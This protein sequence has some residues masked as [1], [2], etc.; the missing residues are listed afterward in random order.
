MAE[1]NDLLPMNI[2]SLGLW[3]CHKYTDTKQTQYLRHAT[4][5][6]ETL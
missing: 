2:L 4:V 3:T 5:D 6:S 1:H